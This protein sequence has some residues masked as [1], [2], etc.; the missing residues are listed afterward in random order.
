MYQHCQTVLIQIK[1][2]IFSGL[3]LVQTV[4]KGYHQMSLADKE[5]KV[6]EFE[7]ITTFLYSSHEVLLHV[8]SYI[9]T[10]MGLMARKPVFEVYGYVSL[11]LS[12]LFCLRVLLCIMQVR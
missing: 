11:Y 4:Y 9:H 3:I 1:P 7:N 8:S 10:H 5:L 6:T 12:I 2:D